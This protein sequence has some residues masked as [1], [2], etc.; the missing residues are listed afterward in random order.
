M[1]KLAVILSTAAVALLPIA[2]MSPAQ[3]A[4]YSVSIKLSKTT[5]TSAPDGTGVTLSGSISPKTSGKAVTIQKYSGGTWKTIWTVTTGSTG[6]WSKTF[7]P[8]STGAIK[9]RAATAKKGSTKAGTS[10][11][12][13]LTVYSWLQLAE[14]APTSDSSD[15]YYDGGS[16]L[17]FTVDGVQ[18]GDDA[19]VNND[20]FGGEG[21]GKTIWNL[22]EKCI[23][24]RGFA[25]IDDDNS[26]TGAI[27]RLKIL[28]DG[29]GD[30]ARDF[31]NFEYAD[32]YL[33]LDKTSKLTIASNRLNPDENTV[34]GIGEP[35]VLCSAILPTDS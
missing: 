6:K 12:V 16:D 31:D 22:K 14:L 33:D 30:Y 20:V 8:T 35:E 2:V 28:I 26:S 10:K 3:A 24:L 27:G 7:I 5:T 19:W 21:I 13:T 15:R 9:F 23:R 25:G 4:T 18:A 32:L 34:V 1:R 17:T 11:S 29:S